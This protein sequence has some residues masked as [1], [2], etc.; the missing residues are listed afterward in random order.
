MR[1]NIINAEDYEARHVIMCL[2]TVTLC[3]QILGIQCEIME[4][5][6]LKLKK[7]LKKVNPAHVWL[8]SQQICIANLQLNI[9]LKYLQKYMDIF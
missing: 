6:R 3:R 4:D 8:T 5:C 1:E 9:S 7:K 2:I